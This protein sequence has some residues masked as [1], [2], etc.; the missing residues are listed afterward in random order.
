MLLPPQE[1]EDLA[2]KNTETADAKLAMAKDL[3]AWWREAGN[4]L[5]QPRSSGGSDSAMY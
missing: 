2:R 1:Y 3:V 4:R 5:Q